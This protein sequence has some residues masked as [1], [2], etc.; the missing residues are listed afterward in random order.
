[1]NK[2]QSTVKTAL[3][4][5]RD[6]LKLSGSDTPRLDAEII[7][8]ETM[9][10]DRDKLLIYYDSVLSKEE[11]DTYTNY[12]ERRVQREPVAYIIGNKE[13]WSLR[14]IITRDVLIPRPETEIV[15]EET[16]KECAARSSS[17]NSP[18]ILE[19]GTGSGVISVALAREVKSASIIA[20]DI[21][22]NIIKIAKENAVQHNADRNIRYFV[23]NYLNAVATHNDYFDFIIS[24]PPYFSESDWENAQPEIKGYEPSDS[25]VG[26]QDGLLFYRTIATD[27]NRLLKSDGW[28]ILEIGSEQSEDVITIIEKCGIYKKVELINDLSGMPR[29]V[30]AQKR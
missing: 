12:V 15:V 10:V 3:R 26:G 21:S 13:F 28:L 23:G 22:F 29:V 16:L 19:L 14:F 20:N 17:I 2:A 5:G 7:L 30:K 4:W 8:A 18:A 24:N 27:V 11:S 1:M 6:R 9:S 25:L